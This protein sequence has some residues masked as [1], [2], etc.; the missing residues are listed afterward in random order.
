MS[1]KD[2]PNNHS[3]SLLSRLAVILLL[4]V[5]IFITIVAGKKATTKS[6]QKIYTSTPQVLTP[7]PSMPQ[8]EILVEE[9]CFV[10]IDGKR[11]DVSNFRNEHEGGNIFVCGTDMTEQFKDEHKNDF[12]RAAEYEVD[13]EG[14][15]L[16]KK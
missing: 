12:A 5:V 11:Y 10:K 14:N 15:F 16:N 2:T 3:Q 1:E 4:S 13:E 6:P 7:T 9:R 8:K